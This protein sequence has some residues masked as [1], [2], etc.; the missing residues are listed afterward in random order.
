ME[1]TRF[2]AQNG[3]EVL[4]IVTDSGRTG[5]IDSSI[6]IEVI[7]AWHRRISAALAHPIS[8]QR[9]LLRASRRRVF[10]PVRRRTRQRGLMV[11][12][13]LHRRGRL[14]LALR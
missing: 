13:R 14:L 6:P 9:R 5:Y 11:H 4:K 10:E 8:R 2:T 7:E 1:T 12:M 3:R